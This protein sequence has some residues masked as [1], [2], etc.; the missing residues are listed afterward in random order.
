MTRTAGEAPYW[1]HEQRFPTPTRDLEIFF[2]TWLF[3]G[4][5][6]DILSGLFRHETFVSKSQRDDSLVISTKQL[7][8]L[9]EQRFQLV[10][11]LD[12]A[13]QKYIYLHAIQCIDLALTTLSVADK[14]FNSNVKNSIASVAELVGSAVNIAHLGTFPGSVGCR[15][16]PTNNFLTREMKA[17]MV[18]ANWCPNDIT[19]SI[20]KFASIELLY[21]LSKIKKPT[22]IANHQ[23]CTEMCC[24]A[25]SI[26]LSQHRTRHCEA[27][28][29]ESECKDISVDHQPVV[30]IL[31][32]GALPLLRITTKENDRS[33]VTVEL[34]SSGTEMARYIA[35]SHVWADGLGNSKA[36]SL[37]N[38]QLARLGKMLDPFAEAGRR[39]L[40]WLDTLCCPV[41][42]G[43]KNLALLQMRRTYA[44]AYKTLILDSAL[45][46]YDSQGLSAA[47]LQ[48][49]ILTCGWM[50]RLWT[51]QE[52]ALASDPWVQFKDG[53]LSLTPMFDRLKR[54][55][56]EN[57]NYRR[58]VQDMWLDSKALTLSHYHSQTG[59]PE[60]SLLYLAL[61]HRNTTVASDEALCIGTLMNLDVSRILPLSG[62]ERMCKVWDLLA[63][64]NNGSLPCKMIFLHGVKLNRRGYRWAPATLLPPGEGYL[65]VQSRTLRWRGSQGTYILEEIFAI[66]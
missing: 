49:R 2:Q 33:K 44:E 18:A 15:R 6:A 48:A 62:D 7:Q 11:T 29:D 19:R 20:D 58:L 57:L 55:H 4:L 37:P 3:F 28:T 52:S 34:A 39:P 13:K 42:P 38:C 10:R 41:E 25:H 51:L 60:L 24:F 9:T 50:R 12:K 21:F 31:R 17:A 65:S 23:N 16:P 27:C 53:P 40:I 59:V 64:A 8:T 54:L 45:Y 56:D 14:N 30:D 1:I 66:W 5:L 22:G 61:S 35:I 32:S 36:N 26:S 43:P 47:E 46:N 63:S